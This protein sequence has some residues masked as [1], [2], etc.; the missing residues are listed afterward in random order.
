MR[1]LSRGRSRVGAEKRHAITVSREYEGRTS[2][3]VAFLQPLETA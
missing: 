3:T 2:E 1:R